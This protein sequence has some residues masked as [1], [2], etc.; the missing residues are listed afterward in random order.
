MAFMPQTQGKS[1]LITR[2]AATKLEPLKRL[3]D[4]LSEE[5]T[6]LGFITEMVSEGIIF[7]WIKRVWNA[8]TG[9][10]SNQFVQNFIEKRIEPKGLDDEN[11]FA[12]LFA[13]SKYKVENGQRVMVGTEAKWKLLQKII[14]KLENEDR[15]NSTRYVKN[16]RMIIALDAIGRGDITIKEPDPKN[17]KTSP[18][19]TTKPDPNYVRPGVSIL[20]D[21]ILSCSTEKQF[22]AYI[23]LI[24][25]MQ[26][27]PFGALGEI[28]HWGRT[29]GI[30][31]IRQAFINTSEAIINASVIVEHHY[32]DLDNNWERA[33]AMSWWNP[34]AKLIA[35]FRAM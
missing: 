28:L 15:Q 2:E 35:L 13:T 25:S 27:A 10:A 34:I 33:R 20:Q 16:F 9:G 14:V 26:N 8:I 6:M 17:P 32:Q 11:I 23:I 21:M 22:R 18:K 29:T 1:T 4:N 24:G 19:I 30:P 5:Y 12:Y 3:F 31:L 7:D